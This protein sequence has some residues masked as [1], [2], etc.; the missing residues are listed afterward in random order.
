LARRLTLGGNPSSSARSRGFGREMRAYPPGISVQIADRAALESLLHAEAPGLTRAQLANAGKRAVIS[1]TQVDHCGNPSYTLTDT[2][3]TWPHLSLTPD[4]GRSLVVSFARPMVMKFPMPGRT[5]APDLHQDPSD[6]LYVGNMPGRTLAPDLHQDPSDTLYVGNMPYG[7]SD[8][9]IL[10]LCVR[11]GRVNRAKVVSDKFSGRSKGF[12]FVAMASVS[13]AAYVAAELNGEEVLENGELLSAYTSASNPDEGLELHADR[14]TVVELIECLL[15]RL[16]AV[17]CHDPSELQKVEW[18][19]LER[20]LAGVMDALGFVVHLTR[21]A[22]DGGKDIVLQFV[23]SHE[24]QSYYIEVKHWVTGKRVGRQPV[25]EFLSVVVRDQQDG[26]IL[27]STSG[28][29]PSATQGLAEIEPLRFGDSNTVVSLCRTYLGVS[30]GLLRPLD[31]KDI[32][33]RVTCPA[34]EFGVSGQ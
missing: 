4:G 6:T 28:F 27:I 25:R 16:P 31:Y 19:D 7:V 1:G 32:I 8:T 20:M 11:Y 24:A 23:A 29:S 15:L 3:G 10:R 18:R 26:G 12:G 5:L 13:E 33:H 14:L 30:G 21:P 22:K 17:I 34:T 2:P 9:G